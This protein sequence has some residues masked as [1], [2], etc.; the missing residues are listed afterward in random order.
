M[1]LTSVVTRCCLSPLAASAMSSASRAEVAGEVMPNSAKGPNAA[2]LHLFD[3]I[4]RVSQPDRCDFG[5]KCRILCQGGWS[6][7]HSVT[8]LNL[9]VT[10]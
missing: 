10:A 1:R 4:D 7:N 8:L 3:W 2:R 5:R 6:R 9:A